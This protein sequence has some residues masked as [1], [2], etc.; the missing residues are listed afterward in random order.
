MRSP[1]LFLVFN[2]PESTRKVFNAIRE[3]QPPRLYIA[4]DGPREERVKELQLCEEVRNITR[5]VDWPCEIITLFREKNLGCK[6]AVSSAIDWFF[7]HELEGIIIEDDVLPLP[8]F[9]LFC[10][11]LL[12]FYRNNPKIGMISG[13]NLVSNDIEL[14]DSYFFSKHNHIWGWASWRRAWQYYDVHMESW[15]EWKKTRELS[16][17]SKKNKMFEIYWSDIFNRTYEK[18]INTWDYQWTYACWKNNMLAVLPANNQTYNLGFGAD[19]T[20]TVM[21]TPKYVVKSTPKPITFPLIHPIKIDANDDIDML[22]NRKIY[23]IT[24]FTTVI[25]IITSVPYVLATVKKVKT[26]IYAK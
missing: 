7:N 17:V 2:R 4:A 3:A 10:D 26:W 14:A 23:G 12:E 24:V 5:L 16:F 11:E 8:S 13:C 18:K 15:P 20:H 21:E 19:A 1:V 25:K 22:I 6:L 9:F